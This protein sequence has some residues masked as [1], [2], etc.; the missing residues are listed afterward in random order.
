MNVSSLEIMQRNTKALGDLALTE[1][2]PHTSQRHAGGR[3]TKLPN[4]PEYGIVDNA[5]IN[6]NTPIE[7]KPEVISIRLGWTMLDIEGGRHLVLNAGK[8]EPDVP[9]PG[10]QGGRVRWQQGSSTDD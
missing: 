2:A 1:T 4:D 3:R 10:L 6:G 5:I 9:G 8:A 7:S